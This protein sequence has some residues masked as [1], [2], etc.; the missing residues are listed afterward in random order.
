MFRNRRLRIAEV[1]AIAA[2]IFFV[3]SAAMAGGPIPTESGKLKASDGSVRMGDGSVRQGDGSVRPG[4]DNKMLLP[5]KGG[6]PV[7]DKMHKPFTPA[8]ATR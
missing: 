2:C 4:S 7:A 5:A 6:D 3:S 8:P 1:A